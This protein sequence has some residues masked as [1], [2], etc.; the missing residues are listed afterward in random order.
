LLRLCLWLLL[1][2]HALGLAER[3]GE[4][5]VLVVLA[6]I[7]FVALEALLLVAEFLAGTAWVIFFVAC[8]GFAQ[9]AEIMVG[10]LQIIFG[11]HAVAGLLRVAGKRLILFEQLR[12]VSARPV[13]DAVATFGAT[14]AAAAAIVATG[15]ILALSTPTATAT[16][17]LTIIDQVEFVLSKGFFKQIPLCP[18]A[19]SYP[20]RRTISGFTKLLPRQKPVT[21]GGKIWRIRFSTEYAVVPCEPP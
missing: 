13:V 3:P 4:I 8:A 14:T 20:N 5:I 9:H 19:P 6:F 10:E 16:G 18:L 1:L 17:L 7:A 11:Q 15:A 21:G 12:C 2:R